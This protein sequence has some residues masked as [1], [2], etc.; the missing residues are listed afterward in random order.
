MKGKFIVFEGVEGVGK[1]TQCRLLKEHLEREGYSVVLTR[2]PGGVPSAED[3]RKIVLGSSYELDP[4]TEL[5]LFEAARREHFLYIIKPALKEGKVVICDRFT[6]STVS[7]QGYAG[8]VDLSLIRRLNKEAVDYVVPDVAIFLDLPPEEGFLRKGGRDVTDRIEQKDQDFFMNV[9]N[10]F[11]VQVAAG[12]L[13]A[14]DA[15]G[16][17]DEISDKVYSVVE[18]VL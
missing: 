5:F 11:Q 8:K 9:Y 1:T 12:D 15:N 7:Y 13:T 6:Y 14:V 4:V 3:I 17:V 10:G 16:T 18:A 2:E